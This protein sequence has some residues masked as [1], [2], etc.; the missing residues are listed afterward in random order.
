MNYFCS[1]LLPQL[2]NQ[3]LLFMK[4]QEISN[5]LTIEQLEERTEFTTMAIDALSADEIATARAAG[6]S[7]ADLIPNSGDFSCIMDPRPTP[8]PTDLY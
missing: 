1:E 6:Y 4:K 8:F 2:I 3:Y 7:E 5:G